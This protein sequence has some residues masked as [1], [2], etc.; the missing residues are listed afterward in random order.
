M[1]VDES[2]F[3]ELHR[4]LDSPAPVASLREVV[5]KELA[6]GVPRQEVLDQLEALR[7]EFRE[8]G[9]EGQEDAVLDVMDF[10]SG[11]CSPHVRL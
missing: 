8:T 11:W 4:A 2:I 10:V 3:T 5:R 6:A 1:A 7:Y 9:T